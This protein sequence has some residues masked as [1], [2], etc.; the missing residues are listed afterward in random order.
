MATFIRSVGKSVKTTFTEAAQVKKEIRT[1]KELDVCP[2]PHA[3]CRE[4]VCRHEEEAGARAP[5]A[6]GKAQKL[7]LS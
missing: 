5:K 1:Q 2:A 4:R 7:L 3:Q 6:G